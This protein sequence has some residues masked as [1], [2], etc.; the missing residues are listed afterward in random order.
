MCSLTEPR[1]A[2][3]SCKHIFSSYTNE[4]S[5]TTTTTT[6]SSFRSTKRRLNDN[7]SNTKVFQ[8][9][10]DVETNFL[11]NNDKLL[12]TSLNPLSPTFYS[13][14]HEELISS[15]INYQCKT[16]GYDS[17]INSS[18]SSSSSITNPGQQLSPILINNDNQPSF[19]FSIINNNNNST[20]QIRRKSSSSSSSYESNHI[21]LC[22]CEKENLNNRK[23]YRRYLKKTSYDNYQTKRIKI[24]YRKKNF[25]QNINNSLI[26]FSIDLTGQNIN[27][28]I[29]YHHN[30]IILPF[31]YDFYYISWLQIYYY[32][33]YYLY[34]YYLQF[35]D[36]EESIQ[37]PPTRSWLRLSSP[38]T[39]QP[40]AIFTIMNYNILC[41]KYATRHVYGYCP[42]WA[43]KWDYRRKQILEELRS[44]SADII[45]LQEIETDQYYSFFLPELQ[46]N[47][48]DG[49]FSPKSRAKTMCEQ[50]RRY[51]DGCAIFYRQSK[52]RLIK[53]YLVEFNQ[54][55]MLAANGTSCHDMMNRVMTKDNIGLVAFLETKEEIYSH[56]FSNGVLPPDHKQMLFVCTA[57]IHWDPEYC[58]VKVVQ[59]F[60]L[61]SELKTIMEDAIQKHRPN[62]NLP[63]DCTSVPLV[64]CG[65]FNSL[66]DSGV[67]ELMRTGKISMNHADFKDLSYESY[68][69]KYCR[70]DESSTPSNDIIHHFKLQSAYETTSAPI[71]PYTNYTYDF[72]GIIDYVFYSTQL[73]R[74][75]GVLGPLD[76]EWLQT[77]KIVGCP[78]PNVPSDHFSLL[79]EFELNPIN[80]NLKNSTTSMSTRRQQ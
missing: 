31:Y 68:L 44:Y 34:F 29:E 2:I 43:L 57:H 23:R 42:S 60:M 11:V 66:P 72:K 64:L 18:S 50:D 55:A 45:A 73:M 67:I 12:R 33:Y 27:Y 71:M 19:T 3:V 63:I 36:R 15:D 65:D 49:V 21:I 14:H 32:Y 30:R 38:N 24:N 56:T 62:S 17:G 48:Y 80:E 61:L 53:E 4:C 69:Q 7:I 40:T 46:K 16:S 10:F 37:P 25:K 54:L 22:S 13:H 41:D 52:F 28:T 26:K 8:I 79:V 74:V 77:N 1:R 39:T 78:H 75:L 47:G 70:I 5:T 76:P 51:V 58:D 9:S 35:F 6:T 59:T 20:S